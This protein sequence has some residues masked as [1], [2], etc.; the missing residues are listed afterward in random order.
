MNNIS[1]VSVILPTLNE[2]KNLKLLVPE[3][4]EIFQEL[5]FNR[6]EI[7]VVDDSSEDNTKELITK[8]NLINN[9][10]KFFSEK[11]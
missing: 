10:I 9:N 11:R 8:F 1:G 3:I 6:Y 7:I 2:E 5:Q 4:V